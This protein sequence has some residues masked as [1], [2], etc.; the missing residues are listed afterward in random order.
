MPQPLQAQ[1]W[2]PALAVAAFMRYERGT[3]TGEAAMGWSSIGED[4]VSVMDS[5]T[6][7]VVGVSVWTVGLLSRSRSTR[8]TCCGALGGYDRVGV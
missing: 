1:T 8:D 7:Y 2:V 5:S 3:T 4:K 6:D